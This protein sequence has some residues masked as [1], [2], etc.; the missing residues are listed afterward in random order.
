MTNALE[1]YVIG[2]PA[3]QGSKRHV[4]NGRMIE[5]SKKVKP[6]REAVHRAVQEVIGGNANFKPF[7]GPLRITVTFYLPKPTTV[8]RILPTVPPDLDKLDRGLL[9][10]L[11]LAGVWEDDS[12]VVEIVSS[13]RYVRAGRPSGAVFQIVELS[14][15]LL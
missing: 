7:D 9:D 13:K 10:A 4:G 11:T 6:W 15:T 2:V 14:D 3:P 5:S 1:L 12:L 8:H